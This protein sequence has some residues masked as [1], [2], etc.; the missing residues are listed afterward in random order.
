MGDDRQ[1]LTRE[2]YPDHPASEGPPPQPGTELLFQTM[3]DPQA[4]QTASPAQSSPQGP[5]QGLP[6]MLPESFEVAI[7]NAIR[8]GLAQCFQQG[9]GPLQ[10]SHPSH[11]PQQARD[12]E[13]YMSEQ[14]VE[15]AFESAYQASV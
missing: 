11:P 4:P 8:Q 3:A 2:L 15:E 12:T 10:P 1:G 7:A 6:L 13:D 14:E 9:G 5:S